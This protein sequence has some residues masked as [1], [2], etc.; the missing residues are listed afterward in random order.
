MTKYI[1]TPEELRDEAI[2]KQFASLVEC[3]GCHKHCPKDEC[4]HGLCIACRLFYLD[5]CCN[6]FGLDK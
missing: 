6:E 3:Q 1:K 4:A 5:E 2:E